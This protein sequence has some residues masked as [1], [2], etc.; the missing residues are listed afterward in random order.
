MKKTYFAPNTEMLDFLAEELMV[1]ASQE[2]SAT[3]SVG[4]EFDPENDVVLDK[5]TSVWDE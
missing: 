5:Q 1:V 3:V 2:D 4:N